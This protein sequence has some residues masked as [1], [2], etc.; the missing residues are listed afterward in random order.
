MQSQD[1][2]LNILLLEALTISLLSLTLP[3]TDSAYHPDF[4]I[5]FCLLRVTVNLVTTLNPITI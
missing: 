5:R 2:E 1:V 3:I 4:H